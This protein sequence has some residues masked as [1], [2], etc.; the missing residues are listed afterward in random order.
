MTAKPIVRIVKINNTWGNV[1]TED[2]SALQALYKRFSVPVE[3][4]WF[5]PKYKAGVWDGKVHFITDSGRFYN[6]ILQ[7]VLTFFG[8]EY[9]IELDEGYGK[10]FTDIAALK[11]DFIEYT[12]QTLTLYDPY[13]YQW[14]G[15]I[16]AL[17]HKRA[18]C[19]HATGSGKSYT[20]TMIVNY[21]RHKNIN[22]K[23]L[24]MVPKLDLIEQFHEDMV[25][26]GIPA[27]L[28]GKFN[29]SQKDYV[30]P[31]IISTWQSVYKNAKFLKEFTVFIAD[32]CHGLK[33]EMVRSVGERV[34]NCEWR[35]GFTGTMPEQKTDKLLVEGVLGPVVDQALYDELQREKS[36]SPFKITA[37]KL[38]YP[39]E[40]VD[41]MEHIEYNLEKEFLE[42]DDFRNNLIC[43]ITDKYAK[44]GKNSIILVKK[45]DHGDKLVS[46]LEKMGHKPNFVSGEMKI[47]ERNDI[48]HGMETDGGQ[49]TIATVGVYSTGVS[50]NRLHILIFA[51]AGKSKIQTLQSVGRGLRKHP[52]KE[53]LFLFDIGENTPASK[54][55]FTKRIHY[56][57][58]NKFDYEVK[59]VT[60]S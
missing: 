22:H 1:V 52:T 27:E 30:Q 14:R 53:K 16:K 33:A 6:G 2:Y 26:Y 46:M 37:I 24:I 31:I 28:L 34:V 32:E 54:K 43:K 40:K 15:S 4:Y 48:R 58:L 25:K 59:E 42:T 17:Y 57:E 21:L 23:F 8:D 18:I 5:M 39:K 10:E 45:L 11:K 12:D 35:L 20:I 38:M 19:E 9:E 7:R 55:H 41:Q 60:V 50:I 36:I 29:G 51:A 13:I 3:N 49:I 47:P 56:Y 44:I